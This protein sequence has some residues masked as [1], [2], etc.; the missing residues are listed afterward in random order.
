MGTKGWLILSGAVLILLGILIRWRSARYDLKDA[1]ID[2]SLDAAT[3]QAH[4]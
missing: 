4:A 2:F 3:P 1:A